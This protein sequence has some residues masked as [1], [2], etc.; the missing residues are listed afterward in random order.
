MSV[1]Q[2]NGF[3]ALSSFACKHRTIWDHKVCT[4]FC[5]YKYLCA[6]PLCVCVCVCFVYEYL[7][8]CRLFYLDS[9][10]VLYCIYMYTCRFIYVGS[11]IWVAFCV[12]ICILR[13]LFARVLMTIK[14]YIHIRIS[15]HVCRFI[16]IDTWTY[17][18]A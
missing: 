9:V 14:I 10:G 3:P 17:R 8:I 2:R 11:Y 12:S 16:Y 1:H 15:F 18:R 4:Y 13:Y 7:H 6:F 5:I